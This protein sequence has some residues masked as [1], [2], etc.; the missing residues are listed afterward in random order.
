MAW[1]VKWTEAAWHDLTQIADYIAEDSPHY[2][3]AFVRETEDAA[4][5]LRQMPKRGRVVPEFE[6]IRIRELL[7]GNFRLICY[8]SSS[9]AFVSRCDPRS[10]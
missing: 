1:Q 5:A 6:D 7:V 10:T 8:L 3:A 2:A 9:D 4:R